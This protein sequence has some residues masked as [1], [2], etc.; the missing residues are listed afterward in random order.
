MSEGWSSVVNFL[1][2]SLHNKYAAPMPGYDF[3]T[4]YD[5]VYVKILQWQAGIL[6]EAWH[7]A[8][9]FSTKLL[10]NELSASCKGMVEGPRVVD[11]PSE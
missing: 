5:K 3:R 2:E 1:I 10:C 9:M 4:T 11:M 8:T 6:C 7:K